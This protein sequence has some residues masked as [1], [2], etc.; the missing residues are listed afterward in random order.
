MESIVFHMRVQCK[1]LY[2]VLLRLN[3]PMSVD[4]FSDIIK[5]RIVLFISL[6][7]RPVLNLTHFQY[8]LMDYMHIRFCTN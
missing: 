4:Q 5:H 7:C 1:F 8:G 2:A 6:R 3:G